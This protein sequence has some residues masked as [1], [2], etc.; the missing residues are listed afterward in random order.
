MSSG[1]KSGRIATKLYVFAPLEKRPP[2]LKVLPPIS[3]DDKMLAGLP[4]VVWPIGSLFILI[5]RKKEDPFL[6]YHAVQAL[7]AGGVLGALLMILTLGLFLVF[8]IMPSSAHYLSAMFGM[9]VMLGGGALLLGVLLSALFLGWR[10]TEGEMLRLPLIGDFAEEKMLDQTGMTRRQFEAMLESSLDPV[11]EEEIPFP[12]VRD[13]TPS[14]RPTGP[15]R[16]TNRLDAMRQARDTTAEQPLITQERRQQ[17]PAQP[18]PNRHQS[19]AGAQGYRPPAAQPRQQPPPSP[20]RETR[21]FD[22]A[23]P[24][25]PKVREVDLIGHYKEKKVDTSSQGDSKADVLR[26]WLSSVDE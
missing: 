14:S 15:S 10:A 26:Q 21:S 16:S 3:D 23:P 7:L 20:N 8:R 12:E 17:P 22:S 9:A 5:S 18:Q 1:H 25:A 11:Q 13:T 6:H 24:S 4:Y 2:I 19:P